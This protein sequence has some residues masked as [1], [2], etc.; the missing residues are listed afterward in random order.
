MTQEAGAGIHHQAY[1]Q[2]QNLI[3]DPVS[4][5]DEALKM[6]M[7]I[8]LNYQNRSLSSLAVLLGVTNMCKISERSKFK[9]FVRQSF[10]DIQQMI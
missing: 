1:Y 8:H 6:N 4:C 10:L 5:L 9:F 2:Q 3:G 7:N